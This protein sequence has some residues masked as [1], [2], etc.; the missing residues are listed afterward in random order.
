M[1]KSTL[2]KSRQAAFL[3]QGGRCFYCDHPMWVSEP[4]NFSHRFAIRH[5]HLWRF[6]CTAEHLVP[7]EIGGRDTRENIVSAC[8]YCNRQ[9][10]RPKRVR[11]PVQHRAHVLRQLAQGRWHPT[12]TRRRDYACFEM[13]RS[14]Q[15]MN[16]S[17]GPNCVI[18]PGVTSNR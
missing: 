12:T 17:G 10:H 5:A 18:L 6:Q 14:G 2:I 13:V 1:A 8:A 3:A 9:R 15:T 4:E 11:D 7:R 16:P